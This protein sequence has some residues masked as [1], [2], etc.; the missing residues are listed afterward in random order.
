MTHTSQPSHSAVSSITQTEIDPDKAD[1]PNAIKKYGSAASTSWVEERYTVW[2]SSTSTK[3]RPKIQGYLKSKAVCVAWGPPVCHPDD[4][5]K[6]AE[7][8]VA[9]CKEHKYKFVYANID[10]E[11]EKILSE[12]IGKLHWQTIS[13]IREDI[14]H[15]DHV[16]LSKKDVKKNRMAAMHAGVNCVELVVKGPT[17]LPDEKTKKEIEDGLERWREARK[18]TQIAS[19]AL[20]PWIDSRSRRYWV[21]KSPDGICGICVLAPVQGGYQIKNSI[22]FPDAPKGV[23]EDLLGTVVEDLQDE[24]GVSMLT[25]GTSASEE[26]NFEHFAGGWKIK[27]LG[28]VYRHIVEKYH[29]AERGQ[30]RNKFELEPEPLFVSFPEHGFGWMGVVALMK[31]LRTK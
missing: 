4:R 19:S 3:D 14:L 30:F 2:R 17:F 26:I 22:T 27:Y 21:A 15:P 13:C 31:M 23:P 1:L 29:L 16:E 6:C 25:F 5:Q 20:L 7:E 8:W 18:G 28:K 10:G 11:F 12:G 9:F 24:G